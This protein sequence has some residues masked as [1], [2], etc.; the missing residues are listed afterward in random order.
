VR[1]GN[2]LAKKLK[3]LSGWARRESVSCYRIY[4]SDMPEYAFAIDLYTNAQGDERWLYV[5]EYA[6]PA[7]IPDADVRRRRREALA[8]M[9]G[10][11]AV[12]RD[13]IHL[14]TRRRTP[15]GSQYRKQDERAEFHAVGEGGLKFWVNFTDYLDTGLFLDHRITRARLRAAAR[16]RRFLNLFS[17]TGSAT[18]Y[19]AHGGATHTTSVDLS[20]TYLEWTRRNLELNGFSLSGHELLRADVRAWLKDAARAAAQ[21]DL[22]FM[23]PPTFSNSKSM[24]GVLDTQRDHGALILDAMALLA[25]DGL[26]VFSTNA[27]RFKLERGLGERYLIADITAT[28]IP[29][30]FERN[31]RVHQCFEVRHA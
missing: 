29:P 10:V 3:K 9:P 28:T 25:R 6:A 16:G 2:R 22:I 12:T 7:N 17:Y 31:A 30:D 23:D 11:C 14:R 21:F 5:Q 15:R 4:D 19:A 20:N 24:A 1:F 8:A 26:L 27:Q 13:H 18:V